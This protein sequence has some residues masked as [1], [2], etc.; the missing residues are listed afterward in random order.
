MFVVAILGVIA[1]IAI[2][3]YKKYVQKGKVAEVPF[4]LGHFALREVSYQSENGVY[5]STGANED[6][7]WPVWTDTVNPQNGDLMTYTPIT[8]AIAGPT[9]TALRVSPGRDQLYCGYVVIAGA[10]GTAPTTAEAAALWGGGVVPTRDWFYVRAVCDWDSDPTTQNT[11]M[12]RGD[13]D[14]GTA[15]N[16]NPGQ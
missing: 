8:H 16:N 10:A 1:A 5:L 14:A 12:M 11:W 4:M 3:A 2:P 6:D 9:W 7:V 13:R 15:N